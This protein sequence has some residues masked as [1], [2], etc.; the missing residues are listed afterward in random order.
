MGGD[1]EVKMPQMSQNMPDV[2]LPIIITSQ[3]TM[4]SHHSP[5]QLPLEFLFFLSTAQI[6]LPFSTHSSHE[7]ITT[8]IYS[9][10]FIL[11]I[12]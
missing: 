2:F 10:I 8:L 12:F 9:F 7:F 6:N 4:L 3:D 1:R 5:F 11:S